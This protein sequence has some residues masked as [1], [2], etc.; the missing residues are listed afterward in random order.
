MQHILKHEL[1]KPPTRSALVRKQAGIASIVGIICLVVF[2]L[3]VIGVAFYLA[4]IKET[5]TVTYTPPAVTADDD[6]TTGK[7]NNELI[8]DARIINEGVKRDDVQRQS[9][10]AVLSDQAQTIGD[11]N[12]TNTTVQTSRLSTLQTAFISE[13]DRRIKALNDALQLLP[14]LTIPQ[15]TVAKKQITDEITSV[16]GLKA[17]A[18]SETTFDSFST[19]KTALDKEYSNYLLAI[20]QVNLQVWANGQSAVETKVNV[21]GGKYQER[22]NAAT[23]HGQDVSAAQIV[24]NSFQA[25]KATGTG[26]TAAALTA[27]TAVKPGDYNA[28]RSVL[29]TYYTKLANAHDNLNNIIQSA[30]SLTNLMDKL[31]Q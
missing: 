23:D 19:D 12:D 22:L 27:V 9:A 18:A 2:A 28:N 20:A 16:T 30:S 4:S 24:V 17:K 15:Q 26:L 6:L 5:P 10:D 14:K 13:G 1:S 21:L 29:R 31:K 7:S 11:S 3:I 25:N 8:Q